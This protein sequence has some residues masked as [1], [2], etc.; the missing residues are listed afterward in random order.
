MLKFMMRSSKYGKLVKASLEWW[1]PNAVA[2]IEWVSEMYREL[3]VAITGGLPL[4]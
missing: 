3:V 2:F 1:E 4:K